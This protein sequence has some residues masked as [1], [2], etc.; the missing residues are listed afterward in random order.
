M[1][2]PGDANLVK[3]NTGREGDR[4]VMLQFTS[5]TNRRFFFWLQDKDDTEDENLRNKFNTTMDNGGNEAPSQPA[6]QPTQPAQSR[7]ATQ[8]VQMADLQSVLSHMGLPPAPAEAPAQTQ[9]QTQQPTS[10]PATPATPGAVS[11]DMLQA[12]LFGAA[13]AQ[14]R[15]PVIPLQ[16]IASGEEIM[17]TE[18]LA[19]DDIRQ[20]LIQFLP[21]GHQT[22]E[23]LHTT[24]HSPQL[25]QALTQLSAALQSENIN[26]VFANFNLDAAAGAAALNQGNGIQ[27][28]LDALTAQAQQQPEQNEEEGDMYD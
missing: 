1:V 15:D 3:V 24:I 14:Q 10:T 4:V 20:R 25:Q 23:E 11:S 7:P 26:S 12:A 18:L 5:N 21:E 2:F 28:F 8:S 9:T 19:N 22:E 13:Q 27:A 6:P 17:R 16:E